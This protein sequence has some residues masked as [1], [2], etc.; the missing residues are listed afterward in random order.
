MPKISGRFILLRISE[1]PV[2]FQRDSTRFLLPTGKGRAQ[3]AGPRPRVLGGYHTSAACALGDQASLAHGG[4]ARHGG[5]TCDA[6]F[7]SCSVD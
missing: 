5:G 3:I 4:V 7:G 2:P 1:L 6:N